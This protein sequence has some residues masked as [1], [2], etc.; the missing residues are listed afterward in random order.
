MMGNDINTFLSYQWVT[1]TLGKARAR[2]APPGQDL[3]Y[4]R[5]PQPSDQEP[6]AFSKHLWMSSAK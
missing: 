6:G 4:T 2:C 3:C 1:V 5:L